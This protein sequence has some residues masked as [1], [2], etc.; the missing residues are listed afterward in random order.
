MS[1]TQFT[2]LLGLLLVLVWA[3]IF[4]YIVATTVPWAFVLIIPIAI[5]GAM[6]IKVTP[7]IDV[8]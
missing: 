6:L 1:L 7:D 3:G 2:S 4:L 8:L 5:F